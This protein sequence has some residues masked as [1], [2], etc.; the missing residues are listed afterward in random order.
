[1]RVL[2]GLLDS[3][4]ARARGLA[5]PRSRCIGVTVWRP[6]LRAILPVEI[7]PGLLLEQTEIKV[8]QGVRAEPSNIEL[9]VR[10]DIWVLLQLRRDLAEGGVVCAGG[11]EV[12]EEQERFE[13]GVG[14]GGRG[15]AR[16]P[17]L[18]SGRGGCVEVEADVEVEVCGWE[19]GERLAAGREEGDGCQRGGASGILEGGDDGP[20][21]FG[22]AGREVGE[23]EAMEE[24]RRA[25]VEVSRDIG[26]G[27]AE[28]WRRWFVSGRLFLGEPCDRCLGHPRYGHSCS[29]SCAL[30]YRRFSYGTMVFCIPGCLSN[31]AW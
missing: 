7:T 18:A 4:Q 19:R 16:H 17:R 3:R 14:E 29:R 5:L 11:L 23:L 9:W 15:Q 10:P 26:G 30:W 12:R 2:R 25:W 8:A 13:R 6:V 27:F 21:V 24:T 1:M 28:V 20:A 31:G 22:V